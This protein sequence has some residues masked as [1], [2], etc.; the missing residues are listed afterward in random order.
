M[1][2][3]L[4]RAAVAR[5]LGRVS[6]GPHRHRRG[7]ASPLFGPP[8]AELRATVTINSPAAWRSPLRGGLGLGEAYVD[9]LWD[10]DD[11]V[12]LL[13]IA[14]RQLAGPATPTPS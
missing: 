4:A 11:L 2:D 12:S 8:E 3:A 6:A 7:G 13:R 1:R 14:A 10:A 5:A 9:G